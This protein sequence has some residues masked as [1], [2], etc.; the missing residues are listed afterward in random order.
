MKRLL[1]LFPLIITLALIGCG[2]SGGS[3]PGG[4]TNYR[5]EMRQFVQNISVYSR[6]IKTGFIVIPQN[7][8]ELLS[9]DGTTTGTP[10]ADYISAIDGVGREDLFYGYDADNV[11]TKAADRDYMLEWM[12]YAKTQGLTVFAIDYCSTHSY[13]DNSYTQNQNKGYISIAADHRELDNIPDYPATP[14]NVN[15]ADVTVLSEAKNF[16]YL[17]NPQNYTTKTEMISAIAATNYDV[18]VMDL[19]FND[20]ALTSSDLATLKHKANGGRR[21]VVA[22]MSIG[23]A[24]DYRYYWQSSWKT[25]PP[26][27]LGRVDPDWP[28]NYWVQ[29]WDPNWQQIIYGNDQSYTKKIIDAGFDGVYLDIVDGFEHFENP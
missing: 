24:E 28:R 23:Q 5:V 27:W 15:S 13:M 16:L 7:G 9:T 2:G 22:Y 3:D 10:A 29:Y 11:A 26:S 17:I 14:H 18:I 20:T 4:D 6:G 21:L 8:G 25:N 1:S 12:D 19:F